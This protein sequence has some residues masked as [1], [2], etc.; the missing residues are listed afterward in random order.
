MPQVYPFAA[1]KME[2]QPVLVLAAQ[3]NAAA[4]GSTVAV[5][6]S[7]DGRFAVIVTGIGP[8]TRP[9]SAITL[10]PKGGEGCGQIILVMGYQEKA[11]GIIALPERRSKALDEAT[12]AGR[13]QAY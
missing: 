7:G 9:P 4:Q 1:S 3:N 10:S 13:A 2:A 11:R 8:L 6:E 5:V 12:V